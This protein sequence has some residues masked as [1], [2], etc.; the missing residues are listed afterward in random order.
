VKTAV[1][2]CGSLNDCQPQNSRHPGK[3]DQNTI[4]LIVLRQHQNTLQYDTAQGVVQDDPGTLNN[5]TGDGWQIISIS[6]RFRS[7]PEK[8][9]ALAGLA[10]GDILVVWE[11]ATGRFHAS[12]APGGKHLNASVAGP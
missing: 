7:L 5:E 11:G 10:Q 8:F 4:E 6:R 3:A 12:L 9:N 2:G 1:L